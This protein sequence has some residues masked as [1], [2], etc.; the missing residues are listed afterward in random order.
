MASR[1]ITFGTKE[2]PGLKE[3]F[4]WMADRYLAQTELVSRGHY[5]EWMDHVARL[6]MRFRPESVVDVGCGPGFLL[7]R[8]QRV[9]PGVTLLGVDYAPRMLAKV[10][11][12]I[13][14]ELAD[15][16][17]WAQHAGAHYDVILL[18]FVLRDQPDPSKALRAL[19][20]RLK[21]G[22]RVV[23]LETQTPAGWRQLGFDL[24]FHEW[25]PRWGQ[26][27]LTKDWPSGGGMAPYSW[28]SHSHRAW[29]TAHPLPDA[30]YNNDYVDVKRHRPNTDVVMLWSARRP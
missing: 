11:A 9:L 16:E 5:R 14:T 28:L 24:Y 4:D 26:W 22:G 10:D 25:L 3:T 17:E 21:P 20:Q 18:T 15:L 23:V 8:L 1:D 2:A 7:S 6:V 12:S 19:R 29:M 30:F 27:A 13:P